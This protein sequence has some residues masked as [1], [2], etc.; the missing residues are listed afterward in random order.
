MENRFPAVTRRE[1][2]RRAA[3]LVGGAIAA[4]TLAACRGPGA[5]DAAVE[6]PGIAPAA[7]TGQPRRAIG[8]Q[9]YTVRDRMEQDVAATLASV[10]EIGY[11]EVET[12]ALF[13]LS[14]EQFRELLDRHGLVSPSG[15][16]PIPDL[17]ENLDTI[18]A[19]AQT[20]G[21]QWVIVAWL[22]ESER[23]PAG[24]R[25]VAADLNRF[26]TAARERGLRM[27]YHNHEWEFEPVAGGRT[28][29]DILLEETDPALLDFELDL[30]W[31]VHAGHDPLELM[32]SHPN[33]QFPLWHVKDMADIE[34]EQRMVAV[35]QG[36]IDFARKFAQAEERGLRH[37]FVEH[38]NP[39]DSLASI[40]TSYQ[41]V[42][43][44]LS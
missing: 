17:R 39:A 15:H 40:R 1:A 16:Y 41:H 20:L 10:A 2:L 6:R 12:H 31:A 44:L 14:P 7:G 26:A 27:A 33:R 29:Y 25:R 19:T 5:E 32:A 23:T 30:F 24:Y 22:P 3:L 13:G 8:L 34:G 38:D 42:R 43:Q 28:G 21:Q 18:F 4:P 9:L 37:F 11:N 35:G 36:D